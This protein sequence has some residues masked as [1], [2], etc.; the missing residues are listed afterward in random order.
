MDGRS[1]E[2]FQ[3]LKGLIPCHHLGGE[4]NRMFRSDSTEYFLFLL[5]F[6][7]GVSYFS[8]GENK[9]RSGALLTVVFD[10]KLIV[11]G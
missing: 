5:Y 6:S 7:K 3:A 8:F 1:I 4:Q 11:I 2:A 9:N 10:C